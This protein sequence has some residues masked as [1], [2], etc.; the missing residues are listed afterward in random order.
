[1]GKITKFSKFN[2]I[3]FSYTFKTRITTLT[4]RLSWIFLFPAFLLYCALI[5][6]LSL[7]FVVVSFVAVMCCYEIGYISNDVKTVKGERDP[8]LRLSNNASINYERLGLKNPH[9]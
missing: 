9:L 5:Y 6:D 8:T 2:Y 7:V 1:M 4:E 3:P